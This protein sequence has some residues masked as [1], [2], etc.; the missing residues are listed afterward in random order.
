MLR[1]RRLLRFA[2]PLALVCFLSACA[3][4]GREPLLSDV[5]TIDI[6]AADTTTRVNFNID[7][8][9]LE[10]PATFPVADGDLLTLVWSDEFD[11]ATL[12][13][14]IWF[15]ESGDGSQYGIP[16]WGNNE[17]QY[18]LPDNARLEGGRLIIEARRE[19]VDQFGF[20]SARIT[21]QDRFAVRY[22][23]I[24]ARMKL[25]A[26]QGLWPAFWMLP[27]DDEV[28]S[29]PADGV[30]GGFS[31]SG[32]IDIMEAVNLGGNPGPGG[33]GGGN[34]IFGTIHFGG[35]FPANRFS[36]VEY[37]ASESLTEQ[38]NNF[39]VEWDEF[40]IRWY[41]NG[42][43]FATQNSW[44]S[45]AAPFPAPFD[46]PF[47]IILNLAVGG[48]FPGPTD[49]STPSSATMEVE[50]VRVYS[51]EA[52]PAT[53]ADPGTIPDAVVYASDPAVMEDLAFPGLDTF[54]SG[55]T[56]DA[57][58]TADA[59]FSPAFRVQSG[60]A[61]GGEDVGFVA[62]VG[63][64]AGFAS[65][66]DTFEFKVKG[67]P[68]D[69]IEV[70]FFAPDAGNVYN[71]TTYSGST[72]LGNGWYQLSIPMS[73]FGDAAAI[74]AYTGFLMGPLGDQ[75]APFSF[76]LT[77][78]G[79]S[80]PSGGGGGGGG[81]PPF[82]PG[83]LTNGDFEAGPSPWLAGV[84]NPIDASNVIDD[85]G[86][87]VYFVDVTAAGNPFD[88]N[89]SQQ[90]AITPDETYTLTFRARSN[91][92][93]SIVAGIGLS[94]GSFANTTETVNLTTAW[95]D[96]TLELTATAFGD[97]TSRVLFDLGAEIGEVYID[98]VSLVVS[99]GGG[100]GGGATGDLAVNGDFETGDFTGWQQFV[101]SGL[102]SISTDMPAGGM[103]SGAI[104]GNTAPG[105]GGTTEIK[106]ANLGAGTL[107]V[108]DVLTITFDVRGTFGPGGQLNVLSFTEFGGGGADLSDQ[109][110]ISGGVDNWTTQSYN[111][112]LSG[113]DAGGG[114]SLAFNAVCGAVTDCVAD[115]FIDNVS[116]V[117]N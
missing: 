27:Q 68:N 7:N 14:E 99:A 56:F 106:Q 104:S 29:P 86:N 46:Q 81:T 87:N 59:D 36:T 103:F 45:D 60:N 54:G 72:A 85:G 15:F 12:D 34:E 83:L 8:P 75:G 102:Q 5:Q 92:M 21:T 88:V 6:P 64:A 55:A 100:G 58:F 33:I 3:D 39:A 94:G 63:Y 32:E 43:L 108:G 73:D 76:L 50:Y 93:R 77:D 67:L 23:R 69:E 20:T 74:A 90:L 35:E 107:A 44:F 116:I 22:G 41:F 84:T 24:E 112:T 17:Q 9:T 19:T 109:T 10:V 52:P 25:P 28:G 91:V 101:N 62:F 2:A 96:F 78:I 1:S 48:T 115:V 13:P 111:V 71:V 117:T 53:P 40:E 11:G 18:Y 89:L 38:F 110:V 4:N 65:G 31:Q 57:N 80:D 113:S 61:F 95:Q 42:I 79:F 114:F 47:E 70:K 49:G 82:D 30:Y 16:G 51:G 26:G 98:D 66:Y 37:V 97:A 105:A